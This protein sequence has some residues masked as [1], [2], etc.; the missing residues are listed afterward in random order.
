M[1]QKEARALAEAVKQ[2]RRGPGGGWLP[3]LKGDDGVDRTLE[4][5]HHSLQLWLDTWIL[6]P[7]DRVVTRYNKGAKK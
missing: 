4:E 6:P 1:N 5:R 7:L 3:T 2:L